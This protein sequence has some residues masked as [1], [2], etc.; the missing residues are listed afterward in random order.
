MEI[1]HLTMAQDLSKNGFYY[2]WWNVIASFAVLFVFAGAGFYSFSIFI[3]PLENHFGWGRAEIVLTMSIYFIV[4][5]LVGPFIGKLTQ[6]YGS[7]KIMAISA[8]GAGLCYVCV[9]FTQSLWYFYTVYAFLALMSSGMGIIPVSSLLSRWFKKRRGTATGIA[10]VGIS[11]GGL[12]LTPVV[13]II[14]SS[15]GWKGSFWFLGLLV[16]VLA[17]P[18][19]LFLIKDNPTD[20]GHLVDQET[21]LENKAQQVSIKAD[22]E[23]PPAEIEGWPSKEAFR[24]R[25]FWWIAV[26]FFMTPFALMGVLQHQV[27]LIMESGISETTAATALGMIAG[28]G[29]A[30]KLCFGRLSEMLSFR[31]V[32][33]LCFGLQALAILILLNLNSPGLLWVYVVIFGFAMG[34]VV[35]LMPLVVGQFFGLASFGVIF[36]LIWLIHTIGGALGTYLGGL[37]YDYSGSYQ[38]ALLTFTAAYLTS[39]MALFWA[40]KPEPNKFSHIP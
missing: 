31:W 6:N 14:T 24:S 17:L 18:V 32:C 26:A 4:G 27:P 29:G 12:T 20:R 34:G 21:D 39:I 22:L 8:V 28:I 33:G 1:D 9:S 10:M 2:G 38:Y 19:I 11:A 15:F 23:I 36:G 35:V 3:R 13:G 5:G 16:W 40:G 30:G 25:P 7:K 37:I